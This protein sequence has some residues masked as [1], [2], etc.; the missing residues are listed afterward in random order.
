MINRLSTSLIE[1]VI[2]AIHVEVDKNKNNFSVM[3]T[4]EA[5]DAIG[6]GWV[7]KRWVPFKGRR[8]KKGMV[9]ECEM[10]SN[11]KVIEL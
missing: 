7:C 5:K 6:Q 3:L 8:T 1:R 2:E 4:V 9:F 10:M 11:G